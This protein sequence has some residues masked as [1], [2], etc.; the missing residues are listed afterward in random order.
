MSKN[1][2]FELARDSQRKA[3]DVIEKQAKRLL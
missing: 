1:I 2:N 3:N